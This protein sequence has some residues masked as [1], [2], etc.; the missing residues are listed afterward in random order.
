LLGWVGLLGVPNFWGGWSV[1]RFV[2]LV[3]FGRFRG[4]VVAFRLRTL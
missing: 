3:T 1:Y 2:T 4:L